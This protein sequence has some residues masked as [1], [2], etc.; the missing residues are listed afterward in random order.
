MMIT[1]ARYAE[2]RSLSVAT[3]KNH[4]KKL[5]LNLPPNPQDNRQRLIS[6]ENQRKLDDSTRRSAPT[7]PA[8][9]ETEVLQVTHHER[10]E[11]VS[12]VIAEG[13]ILKAQYIVPYQPA[14]QNPL[15]LALQRQ[16]NEMQENNLA[17]YRQIQQDSAA[18][19]ETQQAIAA[20]KRLKLMEAAQQEA[21]ES[22]QLKKQIIAQ[23]T[24]ELELMDLGL[25]L[26]AP[27]P[28]PVEEPLADASTES[29]PAGF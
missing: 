24:I 26:P 21:F 4:I 22:H 27:K 13:E 29:Y 20:A 10:S 23:T 5:G 16:A 3:V 28:Q 12:M 9:V 1:V 18:Q 15:L 7:V 25:V 14:A 6:L 11:E 17:R 8:A 2:T 19:N